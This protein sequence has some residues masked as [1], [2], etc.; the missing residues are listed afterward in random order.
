[1]MADL[2]D[3]FL[4]DSGGAGDPGASRDTTKFYAFD[5]KT[6]ADAINK[7][8]HVDSITSSAA[9]AINQSTCHQFNITALATAITSM[10]SGLTG[11]PEDGQPIIIRIED[12]GTPQSI[13]W[14][15]KWRPVG[16][17]LPTKTIPG[18]TIYVEARYN[19]AHSV[20][21][22]EMVRKQIIPVQIVGANSAAASSVTIPAHQAGDLIVI[23]AFNNASTTTPA[24]P[25]ASGTVPA[26]ALI[27][28]MAASTCS[29][30][31][32]YFVATANN[33]T[34]G[35]WTNTADMIAVVLRGEDIVAATP[36]GGHAVGN[37]SASSSAAFSPSVTMSKTDGTSVLLY[38]Y[39]HRTVTAWSAA[40][41]GCT[42]QTQIAS[43]GGVVCNSKNDTTSDG[44]ITQNLTAS[45]SG[46]ASCV[47]EVVAAT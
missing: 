33:H 30:A 34:S 1:M 26:W 19:N 13:A 40:P 12:N 4:D 8:T 18:S 39:G 37:G 27:D 16:T 46:W 25:A 22:V 15:A 6:H 42:Q 21:D 20:W 24:P 41:T 47:V 2:F 9:P 10:S 7:L 31:T 17:T 43:T 5:G 38:F 29:P 44:S 35:T 45:S 28:T 3:G 11:T 36:Y 32:Y 14:G 23:F